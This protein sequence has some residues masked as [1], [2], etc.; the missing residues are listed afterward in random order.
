MTGFFKMQRSE[1]TTFLEEVHK[2]GLFDTS[3]LFLQ[4]CTNKTIFSFHLN[5]V[6]FTENE[7]L[8]KFPVLT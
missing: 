2:R 5:K 7:R 3:N 1:V 6:H 8:K 4:K